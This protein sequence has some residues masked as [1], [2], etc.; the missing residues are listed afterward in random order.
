MFPSYQKST[1]TQYTSTVALLLLAFV[2]SP[3]ALYLS[4]PLR[5]TSV[6]IAVTFTILCSSLAWLQWTGHS[7]LTIPS[8]GKRNLK[9]K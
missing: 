7:Q 1:G 2:A 3:V 5:F 4:R 6:G 8:L 9:A